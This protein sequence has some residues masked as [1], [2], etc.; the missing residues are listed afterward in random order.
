MQL[1]EKSEFVVVTADMGTVSGCSSTAV[2]ISLLGYGAG[3]SC[4]GN[5]MLV[6]S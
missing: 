1:D 5:T 3:W 4:H 2:S 6:S